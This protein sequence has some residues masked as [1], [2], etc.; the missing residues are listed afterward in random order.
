MG[1]TTA[2]NQERRGPYGT[3]LL[4]KLEPS[5]GGMRDAPGHRVGQHRFLRLRRFLTP[6]K[7]FLP[8][9]TD[10]AERARSVVA[11]ALSASKVMRSAAR[12]VLQHPPLGPRAPA[13]ATEPRWSIPRGIPRGFSHKSSAAAGGVGPRGFSGAG[14]TYPGPSVPGTGMAR[15]TSTGRGQKKVPSR[16]DAPLSFALHRGQQRG[17]TDGRKGC[18]WRKR[19]E[20]EPRG[21]E[22]GEDPGRGPRS[23]EPP[24]SYLS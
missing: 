12:A 1:N 14:F 19:D 5:R 7:R 10:P 13:F 23:A 3:G 6:V 9:C 20:G 17:R 4:P 18:R 11:S 15:G 22:R 8:L 16:Q 24:R 21:Q 2:V